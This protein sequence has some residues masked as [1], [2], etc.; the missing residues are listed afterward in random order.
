VTDASGNLYIGGDFTT[1]GNVTA[2]HVA[3]WNGTNWSA[4]GSGMNNTVVALAVSGGTL[5]AGGWFTSSRTRT[6]RISA[7]SFTGC[8]RREEVGSFQ[9]CPMVLGFSHISQ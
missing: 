5:Y 3:R 6:R 7:R 2:N 1:A 9:D 8:R 4:L